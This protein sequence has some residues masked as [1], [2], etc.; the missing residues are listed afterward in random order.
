MEA[1]NVAL[2]IRPINKKEIQNH[3][4]NIWSISNYSSIN[5]SSKDL[6]N[7]LK[8]KNNLKNPQYFYDYCFQENTNNREIYDT[9]A[10][11]VVISSLQGINGTIFMY[12]QTGSGK[13][14]TMLGLKKNA[15][16]ENDKIIKRK[17]TLKEENFSG[18]QDFQNFNF[19]TVHDNSGI[20]IMALKDIFNSIQN[21]F[22]IFFYIFIEF[23]I[24]IYCN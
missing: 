18:G 12:G 8:I 5:L 4:E 13:T 21:V 24:K 9:I 14:F 22:L 16:I 3:E 23:K 7:K 11:K 1:I 15:E 19:N 6:Q 10:K 17:S 20:L 2:R